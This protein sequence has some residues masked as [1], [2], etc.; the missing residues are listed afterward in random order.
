MK[1]K[2]RLL[3]EFVL[4]AIDWISCESLQKSMYSADVSQASENFCPLAVAAH[5]GFL[6]V[7]RCLVN[8]LGAD[9]INKAAFYGRTPKK[10]R[11]RR[12]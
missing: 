12:Q 3:L 7:L 5:G 1:K 10:A 2:M 6:A 8:E 11:R 4:L 9:V